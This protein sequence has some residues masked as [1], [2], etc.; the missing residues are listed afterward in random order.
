MRARAPSLAALTYRKVI[1]VSRT[2]LFGAFPDRQLPRYLQN[3][4]LV[5]LLG[6]AGQNYRAGGVLL[7]A[8][9]PGGGTESYRNR[10]PQDDELIPYISAFR[11][12]RPSETEDRFSDMSSNYMK[13]AKTWNLW[14][15]VQPVLD[16]CGR[17]LDEV[18]YANIC[19]F[20]T[21]KDCR[22]HVVPLTRAINQVAKPLVCGLQP[23]T[24]VALGKKAGDALQGQLIMSGAYFVVP[25]TNGD[26]Y[27]SAQT[28]AV[29]HAIR[30]HAD[31]NIWS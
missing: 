19:P 17:K 22:P 8:V 30:E 14:G 3:D 20:R 15:I 4:A 23:G 28:A 12:S 1:E 25:R 11:A 31:P 29:L 21:Y 9:N 27:V 16:A 2:D 6:F 24:V 5:P 18:A 13:Q 26:S 10:T 7:L